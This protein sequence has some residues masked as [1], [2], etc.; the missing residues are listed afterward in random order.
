MV[1][2]LLEIF[3]SVEDPRSTKNRLYELDEVLFLCI[4]AVI[5]GAE[6]WSAIAQFGRAKLDWLRR[7]LP[8]E[9]G[10]PNEDSLA[11]IIGC[12]NVKAF[13]ACFIE[14]VNG[15]AKQPDGEIIAVDGKTARRSHHRKS[16][17]NSLHV[18][19][20]WACQQHLS[21][22][23][24]ATDEK[25]NE[26]TAIPALLKLLDIIKGALVTIDAMG[27]QTAIAEQIIQ[28][29]GDYVLALKGNQGQLHEAVVDYFDA[30]QAAGF[31]QAGMQHKETLDCGHGRIET[32]THY[33]TT[34][35]RTLPKAEAWKGL[36]SIGLVIAKREI[37]ATGK[38]SVERRYYI[39]SI[40]EIDTFAEATRSH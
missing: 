15:V 5:S 4:C 11:W 32:R 25:S 20:V 40:Q 38:T 19:S 13:E 16:G 35:L 33:L 28:Q 8:Y 17:K 10:I 22:G 30:A 21:L 7:Y 14:W 37:K 12:L 2:S 31:T 24:V 3:G 26:I 18:V 34:D 36:I 23:Q 9:N 6:G 39:N 29:K 27:C 1:K